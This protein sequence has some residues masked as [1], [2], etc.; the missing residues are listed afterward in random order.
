[1]L[2]PPPATIAN[3]LRLL[4]VQPCRA[5]PVSRLTTPPRPS[6]IQAT[7]GDN[8]TFPLQPNIA[9][10]L[11]QSSRHRLAER[12]AARQQS[13]PPPTQAGQRPLA[14]AHQGHPP[15]STISRKIL[16]S[17]ISA[18]HEPRPGHFGKTATGCLETL[19]VRRLM[20]SPAGEPC[21]AMGAQAAPLRHRPSARPGASS[22]RGAALALMPKATQQRS[23]CGWV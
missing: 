21:Q 4:Q 14:P 13:A 23:F 9:A 11:P 2:R 20:R 10:S 3:C 8:R 16:A 5:R 19:D 1:M 6:G 7:S 12:Q 15:S 22:A 17:A 18:T